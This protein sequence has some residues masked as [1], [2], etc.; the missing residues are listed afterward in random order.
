V[1]EYV[2]SLVIDEPDSALGKAAYKRLVDVLSDARVTKSD[3]DTGVF[4]VTLDADTLDDALL[5]VWDGVAAAG[6]DD[7]ILFLEHPDVP[8]HWRQRSL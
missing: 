2:V 6:A 8:E 3:P 1:S 5:R 4:D 7:E